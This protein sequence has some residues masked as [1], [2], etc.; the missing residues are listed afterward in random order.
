[1]TTRTK[2]HLA[3]IS[4]NILF[5]LNYS[6]SKSVLE[7]MPGEALTIARILGGTALF[8]TLAIAVVKQKAAKR[9]IG[10][11]ILASIFGVGGNQFMFLK[12]LA[13]TSPVDASII[14][15]VGPVLVLVFSAI[16]GRDRITFL[17]SLGI[18]LGACG[19]LIV[20]F[21]GGMASFSRGHLGGN[22][23]IFA[24]A[25]SYSCYLIVVKDLIARYSPITVMAWTFGVSAIILTPLLGPSLVK[26]DWTAFQP[27][28][29]GALVFVI[30]GATCLAYVCVAGSLK[31]L[32]PTTA[33]IYTYS[34]PII[35]SV[36]AIFR[37]QDH[38]DWIKVAAAALVFSGVFLVTQS[39]SFDRIS[40]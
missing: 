4:A 22:L 8:V 25:V 30:L 15:T 3:I 40:H 14:A 23:L 6:Y 27:A 28:A 5:G 10:L 12:G 33:S 2:A 21:Y 16:L 39:Y 1:M 7:W 13:S 38:L 17:K 9:D 29:W 20:I 11:L 26:T 24:A 37:G 35:A 18:G 36:F 19:A 32:S 34:Q 31:G